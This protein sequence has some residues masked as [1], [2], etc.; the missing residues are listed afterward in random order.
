MLKVLRS[1]SA[2]AQKGATILLF[3]SA[4]CGLGAAAACNGSDDSGGGGGAFM[5]PGGS[6]GGDGGGGD[7]N[8]VMLDAGNDVVVPGPGPLS[9]DV[10]VWQVI[11]PPAIATHAQALAGAFGMGATTPVETNGESVELIDPSGADLVVYATGTYEYTKPLADPTTDP[12]VPPTKDQ[13]IALAKAF[14]QGADTQLMAQHNAAYMGY[15]LTPDKAIF[16]VSGAG[17][18]LQVN[19]DGTD[20]GIADAYE[21]TIVNIVPALAVRTGPPELDLPVSGADIQVRISHGMVISVMSAWRPVKLK[22]AVP[23]RTSDRLADWIAA[24]GDDV[25]STVN[26][27]IPEYFF[28]SEIDRV[29][30]LA[31]VYAVPLEALGGDGGAHLAPVV[32]APGPHL[33]KTS[34]RGPQAPQQHT[35]HEV[36]VSEADGI[37]MFPEPMPG[38]S[39]GV[40]MATVG[41]VDDEGDGYHIGFMITGG[42]VGQADPDLKYQVV[43]ASDLQ[44]LVYQN[45]FIGSRA[46][47]TC[48]PATAPMAWGDEAGFTGNNGSDAAVFEL[49]PE[50]TGGPMGDAGPAFGIPLYAGEVAPIFFDTYLPLAAGMHTLQVVVTDQNGNVTEGVYTA[51]VVRS[52][53]DG[54]THDVQLDGPATV[55][56]ESKQH[57]VG[58]VAVD[59]IPGQT[60]Y[61]PRAAPI[62]RK[63]R[64]SR[65]DEHW[66]SGIDTVDMP[67][68]RYH[69]MY[70]VD[71]AQKYLYYDSSKCVSG[72][73][74]IP[75][76]KDAGVPDKIQC[77]ACE[78]PADITD[79]NNNV[80][81]LARPTSMSSDLK[82]QK[83]KA[84]PTLDGNVATNQTLDQFES[85]VTFENLPGTLEMKFKY[86]SVLT[87]C[88]PDYPG[89]VGWATKQGNAGAVRKMSTGLGRC[90]GI[91]PEVDWRYSFDTTGTDCSFLQKMCAIPAGQTTGPCRIETKGTP[92]NKSL[93][94]PATQAD[95]D[96]LCPVSNPTK[97][98]P[99][100]RADVDI[101]TRYGFGGKRINPAFIK[102]ARTAAVPALDYT[103]GQLQIPDPKRNIWHP[104]VK[105]VSPSVFV[106]PVPFET[107]GN[108]KNP[109]QVPPSG[110][111]NRGEGWNTA[112]RHYDNI[113]IKHVLD[114][115]QTLYRNGQSY[116]PNFIF[117]SYPA[118][119]GGNSALTW[120][121]QAPCVH[122]HEHW[123]TVPGQKIIPGFCNVPGLSLPALNNF[124]SPGYNSPY[125]Q[126]WYSAVLDKV[127]ERNSILAPEALVD[128]L[129]T[130]TGKLEPVD[131]MN[132][133]ATVNKPFAQW[134]IAGNLTGT[135]DMDPA[136]QTIHVSHAGERIA[137]VKPFTSPSGNK[138][139]LWGRVTAGV[140]YTPTVGTFS[141]GSY[142]SISQWD[143]STDDT[144]RPS[145]Q[146]QEAKADNA[147]W[148]QTHLVP[149]WVSPDKM[150]VNFHRKQIVGN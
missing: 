143:D 79:S 71:F 60:L 38:T 131:W 117:Y 138:I 50:C 93:P 137:P 28:P 39:W 106:P 139:A 11:D 15:N 130:S 66:G 41:D 140:R 29:P 55:W 114:L 107:I 32:P 123:N 141:P 22:T 99:V 122:I 33:G 142:P 61:P 31:P 98:L 75:G 53:T 8:T 2:R 68:W 30:Y 16:T 51:E 87:M 26:D 86:Q 46:H 90:E 18:D 102:D 44:G 132:S 124:G 134:K 42:N 19:D 104:V 74:A 56:P 149:A 110:E 5:A 150:T 14:L 135:T 128:D 10:N 121:D 118:F 101:Y 3:S 4:L 94:K 105:A 145:A 67:H 35:M 49:P 25:G 59:V 97:K 69:L 103:W 89:F 73:Y 7:S 57:H 84:P 54:V 125:N 78:R 91:V 144:Y 17:I 95:I 34:T 6:G 88:A 48:A 83:F 27:I 62:F 36:N 9:G 1:L 37:P 115:G 23:A 47:S 119:P 80:V 76:D 52:E 146:P 116:E 92:S 21:D 108:F 40:E 109:D 63:F 147:H 77:G 148:R 120:E 82:F 64:R 43:I 133:T 136:V 45:N 81:K 65:W 85:S 113:H 112:D 58:P 126:V 100:V 129:N 70:E 127:S 13:A 111:P 20:G 72:Q 96:A 12:P 24:M